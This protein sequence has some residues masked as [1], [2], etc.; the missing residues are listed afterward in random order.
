MPN[1][2]IVFMQHP[3]VGYTQPFDSYY[4]QFD[5]MHVSQIFMQFSKQARKRYNKPANKTWFMSTSL[6]VHPVLGYLN[7][8]R[9][10]SVRLRHQRMRV[11][12]PFH[13]NP[14]GHHQNADAMYAF[15]KSIA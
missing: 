15:I 9:A 12:N 10:D 6:Q 2:N 4:A 13:L 7:G 11:L 8:N 1:I 14:D 5:M 3:G